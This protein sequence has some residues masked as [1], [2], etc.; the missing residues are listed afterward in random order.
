MRRVIVVAGLIAVL[1]IGQNKP[2]RNVWEGVYA[3]DQAKR[4]AE[5]YKSS[6]AM[7]HGETMQG[8]GG[9]PAVAGPEFLF[10]WNGKTAAELFDYLR[11]MMP[12]ADPGSLG[13]QKYAD[14][15]AAIFERNGFPANDKSELGPDPSVLAGIL[16]TRERP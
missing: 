10:S 14:V 16:I 15:M 8:G 2:S 3:A 1:G 7:C 6:C 11:T 4:G 12:P 13:D 9:I 5:A